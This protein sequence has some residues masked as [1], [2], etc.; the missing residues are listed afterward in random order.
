[1]FERIAIVGVGLIGGS[2]AMALRQAG[3]TGRIT[4]VSSAAAVQAAL[5]KNIIDDAAPLADA[6]ADADLVFLAQPVGRIIDTLHKIDAFVHQNALITDVGSTKSAITFTSQST[7][8]RAQFLGGHPMAGKE[9]RGVEAAEAS[10]FAGRTWVLTPDDPDE[11][12]TPPAVEFRSWLD[13]IGARVVVTTP[14]EHDRVVALTSHLPQL[15]A[16][17]LAATVGEGV[18]PDQLVIAGTGLRDSTRLALSSYDL[19]RDIVATNTAA[20]DRALGALIQRLDYLRANLRTREL[21]QEFDA[22]AKL[23]RLLRETPKV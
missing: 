13:R 9:T 17:A 10:L 20:I 16:T 19:W 23:A 22:G 6:A 4:G 21:E 8:A 2:F 5:D 18:S 7:I 11:L 3:F 15:L 12:E 1:M 14:E